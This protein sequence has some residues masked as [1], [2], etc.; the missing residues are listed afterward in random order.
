MKAEAPQISL[1]AFLGSLSPPNTPPTRLARICTTLAVLWWGGMASSPCPQVVPSHPLLCQHPALLLS[2]GTPASPSWQECDG[3]TQLP[4]QHPAA[5]L[6]F[7]EPARLQPQRQSRTSILTP[8]APRPLGAAALQG[9]SP[10]AAGKSSSSSSSPGP[11]CTTLSKAEGKRRAQPTPGLPQLSPWLWA[12]PTKPLLPAP[13]GFL[14]LGAGF[15]R[16]L[17]SWGRPEQA[18]AFQREKPK[19]KNF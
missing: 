8:M 12:S 6:G 14:A 10:R 15:S 19:G 5:P 17:C 18:L 1:A 4:L 2:P 11:S 7:E 13:A 16:F 3:G 9:S